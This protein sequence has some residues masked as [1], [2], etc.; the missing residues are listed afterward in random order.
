MKKEKILII[1]PTYNEKENILILI[2][3]INNVLN[4]LDAHILVVDDNSPDGTAKAVKDLSKSL[5]NLFILER[6]Q[7]EGLGKAYIAG[8]KWALKRDYD[9][10]F[11]MDADFSHD[12]KYLR[13]FLETIQSADL[14]IGS[15]Y[16]AGVNVV[17]WPLHRLLLSYFGNIGARL[18]AGI[19]IK[20]CTSG[21]KCFRREVL[22]SI[23]FD[24]ISS[25]GYSF[26]VEINYHVWKNKFRIKEIPIIFK[27]RVRGESKMSTKIIREAFLLFWRLRFRSLFSRYKQFIKYCIVGLTGAFVDIGS[28]YVFVDKI[29]IPLLVATTMSFILAVINNFFLNKFWTFNEKSKK[30]GNQMLKF[31]IVSCVGLL[32]T[33]LLMF[34][35]VELLDLWYIFAKIITV[36]IVLV[37]NFLGNKYWTFGKI[38]QKNAENI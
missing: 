1:I 10:V 31:F 13:D 22:E 16:I 26:Q 32:I 7:K 29:K 14:V 11:E 21:F 23:N 19:P 34:L 12:P 2:H 33:N 17:N 8:F 28:L 3:E 18:V 24:G 38:K 25:S 9:L 4:G 30:Y 35:Q 36:L 20:D 37:W 15:R 6:K 5:E 27:D